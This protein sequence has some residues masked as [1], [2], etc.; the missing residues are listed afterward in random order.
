MMTSQNCIARS[1]N[2]R[3]GKSTEKSWPRDH[4]FCRQKSLID[5]SP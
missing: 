3:K 4:S 5:L 2:Y 1:S